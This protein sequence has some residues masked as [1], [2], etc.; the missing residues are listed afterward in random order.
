MESEM[1]YRRHNGVPGVTLVVFTLMWAVMLGSGTPAI[2][3]DPPDVVIFPAGT[4][5]GFDLQIEISSNPN[6]VN[7]QFTD[8]NGN[9]VRMLTAGKGSALVFTNLSNGETLS[10]KPSGAVQRTTINADGSQTVSLT[11][12][13][14]LI[15]FPTDKPAGPSTTLYVGQVTF[16]AD[17]NGVFTLQ[18]ASGKSTD[19]CRAVGY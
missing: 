10:L 6:Q 18:S 14:V 15:L 16:T 5:C 19:I 7:R 4:A 8:K 12:N 17:S 1:M 2:A 3:V 9:V 11:G 13:N